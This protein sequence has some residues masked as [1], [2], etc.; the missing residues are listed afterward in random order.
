MVVF[1]FSKQNTKG[2]EKMNIKVKL[3]K[4]EGITLLALVVI[5]I[6]YSV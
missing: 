1:T 2:E 5:I 6:V 3:K 4:N